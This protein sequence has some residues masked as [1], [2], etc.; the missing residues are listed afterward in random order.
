M[1]FIC[2]T[3]II[4]SLFALVSRVPLSCLKQKVTMRQLS[5]FWLSGLA[6]TVLV[7]EVNGSLIPIKR[8][9]DGKISKECIDEI[10][11]GY[12]CRNRCFSS[13]SDL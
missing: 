7:T 9:P 8:L 5:P 1:T 11:A 12:S 6:L 13:G 2:A 10:N 4:G 3:A